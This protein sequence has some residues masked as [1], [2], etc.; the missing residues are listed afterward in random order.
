MTRPGSAS[1]FSV[2]GQ[3]ILAVKEMYAADTAAVEA[4]VPSLTLM[5][6]AGEAIVREI[7]R[8]W[9]PGVVTVLCGPGNN[10]GDGFVVARL[11][12]GLGWQARVGMLGKADALKG[13]AAVNAKR[14]Q[15]DCSGAIH[16]LG[17]SILE[18]A[19]VVV[20]ALFGA[21]LTRPVDGAAAAILSAHAALPE[22][23]PLVAVD[24]PSGVHGDTGEVL[25]TASRADVT[26]TFFRPKPGHYLLP[27]RLQCGTL[28]VADIGI[29]DDVLSAIKPRVA[30]NGTAL[31]RV[32]AP[33]LTGHKFDRGH[34]LISGGGVGAGESTGAARLA[35]TA[36]ARI[37]AGLTTIAA[38][39]EGLP[40]YA[41]GPASIMV[42]AVDT[43]GFETL[44]GDRR[45]NAVLLGPGNGVTPA[46]RER[47]LSVL[48]GAAAANRAVVL[49]ADALSVFADDP[50]TLFSAIAAAGPVMLTPHDGEFARLFDA[51]GDRLTRARAAAAASGAIVVL[52]GGDT[53]IAAPDGRA[54]INTNAPA[55]LATAGSGDVLAGMITGLLAQTSAAEMDAFDAA[56]AAVWIHGETGAIAGP[57][58]I[59]DDLPAVLPR[60]LA[61]LR[62]A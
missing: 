40:L 8:R 62:F 53:V 47:V 58:L 16:N 15:D 49:D 22:R 3:E 11:L 56:A 31:W 10:G 5:E 38:P 37:G 48:A 45:L 26:V 12:T 41:A 50:N 46:T 14:W 33:D 36:A 61:A 2:S 20:D 60:V 9:P 59:A 39:A 21:G 13:D 19:T 28:A 29:P 54:V 17:S 42:R 44:L 35:A 6:N 34:A 32:P 1:E 55:D 30:V 24:I 7:R 43:A 52:K 18:G 51:T 23:I 25:G 4:G 27:G 57:G